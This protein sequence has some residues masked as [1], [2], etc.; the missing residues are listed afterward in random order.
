VTTNSGVIA[1]IA[2]LG[3]LVVCVFLLAY[4]LFLSVD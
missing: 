4:A 1:R 2:Y 3:Y